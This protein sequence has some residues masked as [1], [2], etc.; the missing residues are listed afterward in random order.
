MFDDNGSAGL[1]E[2][3]VCEHKE[4]GEGCGACPSTHRGGDEV[5]QGSVE[6]EGG[7]QVLLLH[8]EAG[9]EGGREGGR[10]GE[11]MSVERRVVSAIFT[12][13]PQLVSHQ[14]PGFLQ[15]LNHLLVLPTDI[16]CM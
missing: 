14:L 15:T 10:E 12:V 9:C 7:E 3:V 5:L 13:V 8:F 4:V 2:A 11:R 6:G 1:N 16:L